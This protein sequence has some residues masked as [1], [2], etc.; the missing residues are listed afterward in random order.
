[1]VKELSPTWS[2]VGIR[3]FARPNRHW[4]RLGLNGIGRTGAWYRKYLIRDFVEQF[5]VPRSWLIGIRKFRK[6]DHPC[7]LQ[8]PQD[9]LVIGCRVVIERLDAP[10]ML[11]ADLFDRTNDRAGQLLPPIHLSNCT[12]KAMAAAAIVQSA[13]APLILGSEHALYFPK[14]RECRVFKHF[15][16]VEGHL[17]SPF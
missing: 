15:S 3:G 13:F 10:V 12:D 6:K 16:T 2:F 8:H 1:M 4:H 7:S 5:Q 14:L 17:F 11:A 9:I